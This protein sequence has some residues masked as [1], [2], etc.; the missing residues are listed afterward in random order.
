MAAVQL[1]KRGLFPCA[2]VHPTL[3]VSIDML[4]FVAG[5][6]VHLPPNERAWASNLSDFLKKRG[7][8]LH[9]SVCLT[10]RSL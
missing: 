5:L 1:V 8:R 3:A 9:T 2:P 4:E 6:F 7:Y 10:M